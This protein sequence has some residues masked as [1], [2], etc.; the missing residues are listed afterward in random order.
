[1]RAKADLL[2]TFNFIGLVSSCFKSLSGQTSHIPWVAVEV[3]AMYS[4]SHDDMGTPRCL[5][6]CQLTKL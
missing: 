6:E 2:S 5:R 3:G 1:M 4:A